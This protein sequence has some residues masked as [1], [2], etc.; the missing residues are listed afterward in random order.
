[1]MWKEEIMNYILSYVGRNPRTLGSTINT[2][3][4]RIKSREIIFGIIVF[5]K[6]DKPVCG[7]K[8]WVLSNILNWIKINIHFIDDG[9]PNIKC[10]DRLSNPLITTHFLN[11]KVPSA[12]QDLTK[13][14]NSF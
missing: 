11:S 9:Y 10:V 8:G 1:M 2:I 7:T 4:S 12:K 3:C 13:L 14:L 6:D 5:I